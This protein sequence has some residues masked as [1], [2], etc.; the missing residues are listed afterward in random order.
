MPCTICRETLMIPPCEHRTGIISGYDLECGIIDRGRGWFKASELPEYIRGYEILH[1]RCPC[2]GCLIKMICT[3]N[4][5]ID[6][7]TSDICEE[8]YK[9]IKS[10]AEEPNAV[11]SV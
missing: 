7:Y 11:P 2:K 10:F 4:S 9:L 5:S 1:H 6:A 3:K 8:Y